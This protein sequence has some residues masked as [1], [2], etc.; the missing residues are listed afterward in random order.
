MTMRIGNPEI[1]LP[2]KVAVSVAVLP[3]QVFSTDE[4]MRYL[5]IGF[6]EDLVADLSRFS[7][8]SLLSLLT[9]RQLDHLTAAQTLGMLHVDYMVSGSFRMKGDQLRISTRLTKVHNHTVI[10]ADHQDI[11]FAGLQELEDAVGRQIVGVLQQQIDFDLLSQGS[12]KRQTTP[13]A[14][15]LWLRGMALLKKGTSNSDREARGLF[16]RALQIDPGFARAYTGISL[17][18]FN[19]WS[20]QLWDRWDVSRKGAFEY[21]QQAVQLNEDDH[22][23]WAVLGRAHLFNEDYEQAQHCLYKSIRINP[24]DA[25][26]LVQVAFCFTYLGLLEEAE[27]LYRKALFLH[28]LHHDEYLPYGALIYFEM[29]RFTDCLELALKVNFE[30]VW[31]DAALILAAASYYIGDEQAA[32]QYWAIYLQQYRSKIACD[33]EA[34]ALDAITWHV[35]VNPFR[36]ESKMAAF[37][38]VLSVRLTGGPLTTAPRTEKQ[39]TAAFVFRRSGE[40]REIAF[41]GKQ[42]NVLDTK[43]FADIACLLLSPGK[44]M[45]CLELMGGARVEGVPLLDQKAKSAYWKKLQELQEDMAEAESLNNTDALEKTTREYE[46]LLAHVSSIAGYMGKERTTG[47]SVEKARAAVTLRIRSAIRKLAKHHPEMAAYLG[48]RIKTGTF[49]RYV[50]LSEVVWEV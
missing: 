14:Y 13:V 8:L 43:G 42:V 48:D 4:N 41:Q 49:C 40:F 38:S 50:P 20:C 24:N 34:P 21:A 16:E 23:A 10:F 26:N 6:T 9:T 17:S 35:K 28:P 30:T 36:Q 37:L 46:E 39:E 45:H 44:P 11:P 2:E 47:S 33:P 29:G 25:H 1:A 19:E 15:E 22:V 3:Y 5:A 18:Y 32:D 12:K 31:V 7:G 27:S